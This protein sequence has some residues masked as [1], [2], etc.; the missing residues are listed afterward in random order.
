[1]PDSPTPP[2]APVDAAALADEALDNLVHQFARPLD[3]LREL[4]QNSIDAG[5]P[6]I[7]VRV[8]FVPPTAGEA[9]GVLQIALQDWG[10]GMDEQIIDQQLTRMFSS[11]K[12]DDLTKIGKFGIGFT[13]IFAI[14]PEAVILRTGRHGES[15]ELVFHADR[16]FDKVRLDE[17]VAG[18]TVTLFKAM[19]PRAV[20]GFVQEARWVLQYW[21]EHSSVPVAFWDR[22]GGTGSGRG[23]QADGDTGAAR[24]HGVEPT[25]G[26]ADPSAASADPFA[27]FATPA[28]AQAG[29]VQV[30]RPLAVEAELEVHLEEDGVEVLVGIGGRPSYGFYNGGLTLVHTRAPECLGDR[31]GRLA[32]LALK[33][34]YDRLEHTLTRDNV[35]RD[36]HW[37]KAMGV[38]ARAA[39]QLR[40]DLLSRTA[41]AVARGE[42]LDRW[43]GLLARELAVDEGLGAFRP[44][45]EQPLFADHRGQPLTL[46]AIEAQ[47]RRLELVLLDPGPGHGRLRDAL[48]GLDLVLVADTPGTR[49]ALSAW[50]R[51]PRFSWGRPDEGRRVVPA[52]EVFLLPE[53]VGPGGLS[54]PGRRM[55]QIAQEILAEVVGGRLRILPGRF[56]A[57]TG[58]RPRTLAIEGP[59][60]GSV[61]Q[62][63]ESTPFRLPAFLRARV[64]LLD[65]EHPTFRAH[66]LSA[67]SS[68]VVAALGLLQA[69][70]LEEELERD[71]VFVALAR[72][73]G[74]RL[75]TGSNR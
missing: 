24:G 63:P 32:H 3:F 74:A 30:A 59:D 49:A 29:P 1:M 18:T 50:W 55:V 60:D 57:P 17:P 54:A 2:R 41:E 69:A 68:P 64:L 47:E 61:F 43:H 22:T 53:L 70:L 8:D 46:A 10:E 36:V 75:A 65:V 9:L 38:V 48:V 44:W 19:D 40:Q 73:A 7:E 58:G 31:E 15:W 66:A 37:E 42:E 13:S 45:R 6:R 4:V 25:A 12:E 71:G 39:E 27:A 11:T 20:P 52:A 67:A 23:E 34:K 21:C 26:S 51:P 5:T 33:V 14:R 72:A 16:S 28:P 56:P 62:V 35:L